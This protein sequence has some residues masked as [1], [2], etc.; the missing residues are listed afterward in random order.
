MEKVQAE[1]KVKLVDFKKLRDIGVTV[2][3]GANAMR[4]PLEDGNALYVRIN[5]KKNPHKLAVYSEREDLHFKPIFKRKKR[6][7]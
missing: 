2:Y 1:N 3:D 6:R 4:F 5:R 7:W